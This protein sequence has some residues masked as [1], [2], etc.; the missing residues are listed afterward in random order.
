MFPVHFPWQGVI[1]SLIAISV[2]PIFVSYAIIQETYAIQNFADS[3]IKTFQRQI[4]PACWEEKSDIQILNCFL[5]E[6]GGSA[7]IS[8]E[9]SPAFM[10]DFKKYQER[11]R[12]VLNM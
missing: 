10:R 4:P 11:N 3:V 2:V 9:K 1:P 5:R 12:V 8:R 6:G 7:L